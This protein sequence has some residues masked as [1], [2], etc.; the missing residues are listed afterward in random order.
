MK[1]L[2]KFLTQNAKQQQIQSKLF[3]SNNC[4]LG[5]LIAYVF[6]SLMQDEGW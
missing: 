1:I 5:I 3:F 4:L 2:D 6:A